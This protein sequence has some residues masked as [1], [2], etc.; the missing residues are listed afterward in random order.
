MKL[1]KWNMRM[2]GLV[3][4]TLSVLMV[5]LYVIQEGRLESK[6]PVVTTNE[7]PMIGFCVDT[8]AIER[9]QKDKD[10]FVAK[11]ES[12]GY[13]VEA[14][15]AYEDTQKQIQQIRTLIEEGAKAIV[16]IAFEKDKLTQVIEEARKKDIVIIAYDR[17]IEDVALDAYI[18][19]DNVQVGVQMAQALINEAPKGNIVIVNGS[20]SDNNAYMFNE[21]YYQVLNPSIMDG[22]HT[23]IKEVWSERW[24]ED[25]AYETVRALLLEEV[26]IAGIIGANDRLAEGAIRALTEFGL[27]GQIPVV[28]HDADVSACQ[29]IVAGTQLMTVYKPIRNLAE[30]TALIVDQLLKQ[31]PIIYDDVLDNGKEDIP[32]IHFEVIPVDAYNLRDTVIKDFF[33]QE[34]DIYNP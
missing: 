11:A 28:G 3:I 21:G 8:L 23:I 14:V 9:W 2:S 12:L 24:R 13:R 34:E 15:N 27:A 17:L 31:Q 16:I 1:E 18:S 6:Q 19:F 29:R 25:E 30:G 33:H 26:E 5:S 22:N 4:L 10:I 7:K 20:P 32:Y